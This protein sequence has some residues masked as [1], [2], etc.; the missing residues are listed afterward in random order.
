MRWVPQAVRPPHRCAVIPF[1]GN[2]STHKG[3]IDTGSVIP[4][5]DPH[6][7]VSVE[8]VEEMARMLGWTPPGM[9]VGYKQQIADAEKKAE[10]AIAEKADLE[11]AVAAIETLKRVGFKEP[12]KRKA[13][14]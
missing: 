11:A 2:S 1:M 13:A 6:V 14:A 5:W 9:E 7:Y 8:A 10:A 12:V 4:G 3:F